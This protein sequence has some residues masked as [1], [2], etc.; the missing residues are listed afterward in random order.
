MATLFSG[1]PG[2]TILNHPG[3]PLLNLGD[4]AG[5]SGPVPGEKVNVSAVLQ[6][7]NAITLGATTLNKK[8]GTAT[9]NLTLPNPGDLTASG[10]GVNAAS[11]GHAVISK[12]VAAG[13]AQLLI[14]AKGKKRKALNQTGKVKLNVAIT[15]TPTNGDP[16]TQSVTVKLKKK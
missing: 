1:S 9:V 2:D 10:N 13:P 14:K 5:F 3:P 8:K 11:A 15:F 7:T 12:A 4:E 6:P 16:A